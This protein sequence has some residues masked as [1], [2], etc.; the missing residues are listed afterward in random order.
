MVQ[1][2]KGRRLDRMECKDRMVEC[3][4]QGH[5]DHLGHM[6][7]TDRMAY[8]ME[9]LDHMGRRD[10]KDCMDCKGGYNSGVGHSHPIFH[11]SF[12]CQKF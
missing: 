9:G 2:S 4:H 3:K 7:R 12:Y 1:A 5:K 10:N 8:C 6:A 11:P